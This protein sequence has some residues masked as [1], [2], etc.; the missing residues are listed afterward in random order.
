MNFSEKPN[1]FFK[2]PQNWGSAKA[3]MLQNHV[4]ARAFLY[5]SFID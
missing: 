2:N 1:V 5:V 4:A 3:W